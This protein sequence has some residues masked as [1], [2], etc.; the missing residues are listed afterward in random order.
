MAC[1]RDLTGHEPVLH[2][3]AP[4]SLA[5]DLYGQE[6]L[7]NAL[8]HDPDFVNSFLDHLADTVLTPWMNH[9]FE[10]FPDGWVELSDASGSPFFIGPGHCKD[11][12]IRSIQRLVAGSPWS[13]QIY[14]ANYRGDYVTQVKQRVASS[15]RRR[16]PKAS[17]SKRTTLDELFEAKNSVCRD[18]VIRLADDRVPPS[19]YVERAIEE[20]VPLFMGIGA[21]QLDR[22]SISDMDGARADLKVL[23]SEYVEAI[24]TVARTIAG[25]GYDSKV[26]PWPGTLYFEDV[27]AE[28]S[29]EL[30]EILVGS[31]L[32]EGAL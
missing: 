3:S 22:N 14:I 27:S 2:L 31:V 32:R 21:T 25:N 30:I 24:R 15:S 6:H 10:Q 13:S 18:Y 23:G 28:S 7:I 20:N 9:F 26:P 17:D 8:T 4:Y 5:A 11:I 12:A 16:S 19:F 29:F 1:Y